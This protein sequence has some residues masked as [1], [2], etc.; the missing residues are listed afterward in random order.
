MEECSDA[1]PE[2]A[3]CIE[4]LVIARGQSK[5]PCV[6]RTQ[7]DREEG[8]IRPIDRNVMCTYW[9]KSDCTGG[10]SGPFSNADMYY[11]INDYLSKQM[12]YN[13]QAYQCQLIGFQSPNIPSPT[14]KQKN[15][16]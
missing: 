16:Y 5:G 2:A 11:R 8:T 3:Q 10:K 7:V 1:I 4:V 15:I 12:I 13:P 9:E 6:K 14:V